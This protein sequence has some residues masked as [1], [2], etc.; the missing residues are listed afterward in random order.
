MIN[1]PRRDSGARHTI[2]VGLM[3]G[4]SSSF[5]GWLLIGAFAG[6]AAVLDREESCCHVVRRA[7]HRHGRRRAEELPEGES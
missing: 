7:A 6:V 1:P 2:R 5:S 4:S 3:L